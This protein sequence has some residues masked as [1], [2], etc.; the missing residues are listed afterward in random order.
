MNIQIPDFSNA[1]VLIIGDVMLDR[2]WLGSTR[3]ISPEAPVPVVH[4][5]EAQER[6]GGA[7]NVALNIS[8]FGCGA[9]LLGYTGCDEAGESLRNRLQGEG[10]KCHLVESEKIA[11]LVKLR[12]LS[13]HQQLIRLD[14]ED[15]LKE[16]DDTSLQ[17]AFKNSLPRCASVVLS[18]YGKGTL[19]NAAFYIEQARKAGKP[20]LVDPK[21]NDY[22]IYRGATLLTPNASEFEAVVGNCE[23]EEIFREK[24]LELKHSLELGALLV[25]R[26]EK[27]M[28]LFTDNG[29]TEFATHAREVFD[30]TGAGD[31]VIGTLAAALASGQT[32]EAATAIANVAAGIVVGKIGTATASI[33][34]LKNEIESHRLL[35]SGIVDENQLFDLVNKAKS[36]GEKI[37]MTNGCFD[38]LHPGH[39]AYLEQ[40]RSLGSK[41]LVAVN[42]DQSVKRLK[43]EAR[44]INSLFHRMAVLAALQSV[45]WVVSFSEDTP[46]NLIC[47]LKPDVLVKGGDYKVEQIA[48][49]ECVV[50]SGGIVRV[51]KYVD[52]CSTTNMIELIKNSNL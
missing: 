50:N 9:S 12:V 25:T 15:D 46:E 8:A 16:V 43:G 3:R 18:D 1:E 39:I 23:N 33:P 36:V 5:S 51:L 42:D 28:L 38:I 10:V 29:V 6:P 7:A 32:L 40:A 4:I 48:G 41:L 24:G 21:G 44:P 30:V 26:S 14:F 13:Q 20:V 34:E 31:T 35:E 2:Y 27:G 19:K 45:D 37:V 11:T 17:N 52:G 47:R 22:S 49:A